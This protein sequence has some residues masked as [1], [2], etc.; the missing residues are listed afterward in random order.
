MEPVRATVT[1]VDQGNYQRVGRK[2]QVVVWFTDGGA[3][4]T[5]RK[6]TVG[7]PMIV[8][9]VTRDVEV[10]KVVRGE[11][12][13]TLYCHGT[14]RNPD[15]PAI[16]RLDAAEMAE[17]RALEAYERIAALAEIAL[18]E[19]R[20]ILYRMRKFGDEAVD[21]PTGLWA[22]I[23]KILRIRAE[24]IFAAIQEKVADDLA[25]SALAHA[26]ANKV[27][28]EVQRTVEFVF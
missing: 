24:F 23:G 2:V 14:G 17:R 4:T 8:R 26:A 22:M 12:G 15:E 1:P 11:N 21:I 6:R 7:R 5:V 25:D 19:L 20:K 9:S 13:V 10:T 3:V 18:P 16:V 27:R 28:A